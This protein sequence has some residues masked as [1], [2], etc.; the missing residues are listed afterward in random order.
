[1]HGESVAFQT[2]ESMSFHFIQPRAT[3]T[4]SSKDLFVG[5]TTPCL[6]NNFGY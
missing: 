4:C 6:I 2:S 5:I 1:M 3:G